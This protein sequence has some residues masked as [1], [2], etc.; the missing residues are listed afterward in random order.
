MY[1]LMEWNRDHRNTPTHML[2]CSLER[3][4]IIH[5]G[6][7]ESLQQMMLG[8]LDIQCKRIK[9]DPDFT[10]YTK[11]NQKWIK[12][13]NLRPETI[14]LLEESISENPHDIGL[15]N[16]FMVMKSKPQAKTSKKEMSGT[17]L[18]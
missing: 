8:K 1:G 3:L 9:L 4:P 10:P 2:N 12:D 7:R 17:T 18:N 5:S 11:V 14:K 15:S 6:E 16:D 13:L